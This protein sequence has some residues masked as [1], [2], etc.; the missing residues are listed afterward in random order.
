MSS[1]GENKP[2][3]TVEVARSLLSRLYPSVA[4]KV[5][6]VKEIV[7][8]DDR[9][10]LLKEAD[11]GKPAYVLKECWKGQNEMMLHL[12]TH[13][14]TLKV[15]RPLFNAHGHHI[16]REAFEASEKE[17]KAPAKLFAV[18][19]LDFVPGRRLFDYRMTP[20]LLAKSGDLLGRLLAAINDGRYENGAIRNRPTGLW[21][22]VAAPKI[23]QYLEDVFEESSTE[24]EVRS[25]VEDFEA[26]V[27]TVMDHL[28]KAY[29]H[30]DFN[31]QNILVDDDDD[32][33]FELAVIDF[34][35]ISYSPR[36]F[37][38]AIAILYLMLLE[39]DAST[40]LDL[41]LD[42]PRYVLQSFLKHVPLSPEEL[43]LLFPCA[44]ARLA[45]S[46]TLGAVSYRAQPGNE[47]L[48]TTQAKGWKVMRRLE[49]QRESQKELLERWMKPIDLCEVD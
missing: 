48:L 10:Y 31:E 46:L 3:T 5:G 25:A 14:R 15:S 49:E 4:A 28:P 19:L 8:Y 1:S 37:D 35:D 11:T 45:Q 22:L 42:G 16:A 27:L 13:Y 30:G 40:D 41:V 18:R 38:I 33:D 20:S 6:E 23:R 34:G 44:R 17:G 21:S 9:N 2:P 29:I 32:K 36:V 47:Y 24:E 26:E 43:R 39:P 12:A 7:S